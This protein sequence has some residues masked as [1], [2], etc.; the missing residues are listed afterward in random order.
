LCAAAILGG[1]KGDDL[2][3]DVVRE[4][5]DAVRRRFY[6]FLR[7]KGRGRFWTRSR[8]QDLHPAVALAGASSVYIPI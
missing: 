7:S 8:V 5:A 3:K 4:I 6:W 2:P 1:E